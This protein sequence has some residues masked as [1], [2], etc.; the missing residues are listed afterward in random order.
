MQ[1]RRLRNPFADTRRAFVVTTP[2]SPEVLDYPDIQR[3]IVER[4]LA[5]IDGVP[6]KPGR[7]LTAI[8]EGI[9]IER[10]SWLDQRGERAVF[11]VRFRF[12]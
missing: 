12:K 2:V 1:V 6:R 4:S 7:K 5:E 10:T 3:L 9:D 8:I 11:V